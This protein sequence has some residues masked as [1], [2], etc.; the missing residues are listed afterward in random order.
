M[1]FTNT[2]EIKETITDVAKELNHY[3]ILM[4]YHY[5]KRALNLIAF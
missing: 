4:Y 1:L 3:R 5:E 2:I